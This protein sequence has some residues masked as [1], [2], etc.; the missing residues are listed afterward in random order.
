MDNTIKVWCDGACSGNPGPGGYAAVIINA[1]ERISISG[2]SEYTTNNRME[3]TA[4]ISA[5]EYIADKT[6]LYPSTQIYVYTDSKYIENALNC[7][8]TKKWVKKE[9][10]GVKNV[11]LWERAIVL[12]ELLRPEVIWVKGHSGIPGNELVDKFATTAIDNRYEK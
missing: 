8:W 2:F 11:D 3:L 4:F 12:N 6:K 9:F 1:N 7:G 10:R 5:L